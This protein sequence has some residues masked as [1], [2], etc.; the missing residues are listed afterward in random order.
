MGLAEGLCKDPQ[1]QLEQGPADLSANIG[2]VRDLLCCLGLLSS[3]FWICVLHLGNEDLG[4]DLKDSLLGL[5]IFAF[6]VHYFIVS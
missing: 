5:T 6:K 3:P 1:D 2:F 4:F